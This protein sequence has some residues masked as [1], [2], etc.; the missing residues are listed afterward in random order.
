M[1]SEAR[2]LCTICLKVDVVGGTVIGCVAEDS[3]LS[4]EQKAVVPVAFFQRLHGIR[5]HS[6]EPAEPVASSD[7]QKG[8][9]AEIVNAG[10]SSQGNELLIRTQKGTGSQDATVGRQPKGTITGGEVRGQRRCNDW[11]WGYSNGL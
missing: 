8:R 6:V 9:I 1:G 4:V 3:P 11:G 7:L 2:D 10:R 5:N